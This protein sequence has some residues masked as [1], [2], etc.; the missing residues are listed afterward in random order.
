[1]WWIN[2]QSCIRQLS[3]VW[4]IKHRK[5]YASF[6]SIDNLLHYKMYTPSFLHILHIVISLNTSYSRRNTQ[7]IAYIRR[8]TISAYHLNSYNFPLLL[9]I[10]SSVTSLEHWPL[11][12]ILTFISLNYL[13]NFI[14][15][16]LYCKCF[17]MCNN[18]MPLDV[19]PRCFPL[20]IFIYM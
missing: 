15:Y 17:C 4:S 11:L 10:I 16:H 19:R 1:M 5:L 8:C 3:G 6:F 18:R 9:P 14:E 2:I 12:K 13:F 7:F 20:V